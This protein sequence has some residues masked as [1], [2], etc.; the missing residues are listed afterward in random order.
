VAH[1]VDLTT[2]VTTEAVSQNVF[3][4][5]D[6]PDIGAGGRFWTTLPLVTT[7]ISLNKEDYDRG[8]TARDHTGC[9]HKAAAAKTVDHSWTNHHA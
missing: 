8:Q 9:H 3:E 4:F 1:H 5:W 7:K 6:V 2:G